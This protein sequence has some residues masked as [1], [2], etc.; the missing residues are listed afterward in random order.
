MRIPEAL[1]AW[2]SENRD[3]LSLDTLGEVDIISRRMS[4]SGLADAPIYPLAPDQLASLEAL[5]GPERAE[6]AR[7]LLDVVSS[8]HSD[9]SAQSSAPPTEAIQPNP[10]TPLATAPTPA[11]PNPDATRTADTPGGP[12]GPLPDTHR[13]VVPGTVDELANR[14]SKPRN[15]V[16]DPLGAPSFLDESIHD[17]S[18]REASFYGPDTRRSA[19]SK[20]L[21]A[22]IVAVLVV[23]AIAS[24]LLLLGVGRGGNEI[25]DESVAINGD[26]TPT[27]TSATTQPTQPT[28]VEP[29]QDLGAGDSPATDTASG[30]EADTE[31]EPAPD[32]VEATPPIAASWGDTTT[33]LNSGSIDIL[34]STYNVSPANR[35]VLIGH[36]AAITGIAISD[37]GRVLTAGA[38]KRLVDWGADVTAANPD[39]L[40]VDA[41]LTALARTQD[42][43]L[44]AGDGLGNITVIS[45]TEGGNP[46]II[47]VHPVAVSTIAEVAVGTLAVGSVDGPVSVFSIDDPEASR[48]LDHPVEVTGVA[49]LDNAQIATSSVDGFV[50]LWPQDAGD[51]QAINTHDSALTAIVAL[52]GNRFAT[53]DVTGRIDVVDPSNP[54]SASISFSGHNGPVRAMLQVDENTLASGGDDSTVRL[55]NMTTG[56]QVRVLDGHGDLISA[57]DRLPDQRLVSTSADGTARVWD[58]TLP[59]ETPVDPPH[60]L[61]VSDIDGWANDQLVTGGDDGRVMLVSTSVTSSPTL[62][63]QHAGPVIGVEVMPNRDIVSLDALSSLRL[64]EADGDGTPLFE[65]TI[66]PG[67]T[68]LAA[69]G[70]SGVVTGHADGTVRFT[71]FTSEVAVVNAHGSGVNDVVALSSGLIL[72]A[73]EDRTV[74]V[75]NLD[76]DTDRLPVFD[77]HTAA[78][79]VVAELPDG[80][81]ASAGSDGIYIWSTAELGRDHVRLDGHRSEI[82]G[83][84][85]LPGNR[86]LSTA[87]DGRVRL[88]NL[89]DPDAGALTLVDVPGVVNPVIAQAGNGLFV[90]G[91]ARGYVTFA[92]E[93]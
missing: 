54:T 90:T 88:W 18:E 29:A 8:W 7:L 85:G 92:F 32:A 30:T 16:D 17:R 22:T 19:V 20:T 78:V 12:D 69:R 35:A 23:G 70:S 49:V 25:A 53:A 89:D 93:S 65:T 4:S 77:L 34:A 40:E 57:L 37:D 87:R 9:R 63:T 73:G 33:V 41:T 21:I 58:L 47:P 56:E 15:P 42:Q 27:A 5:F 79:D 28:T 31:P 86:L 81:V 68:A 59:P 64:S 75:I 24:M 44:V 43:R 38:D 26:E 45:L 55:W 61:N 67:A 83:L 60:V 80:R 76:D 82:T 3:H 2:A 51:P 13:P 62:I 1:D 36:T 39:V 46:Q 11:A 14:R 72:S 84:H 6:R 50:R 74:R 66:A 91:A 10:A 52:S 71:D 48:S